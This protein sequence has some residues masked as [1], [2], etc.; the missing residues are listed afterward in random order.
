[1]LAGNP[2]SVGLM[3]GGG[4]AWISRSAGTPVVELLLSEVKLHPKYF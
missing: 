3:D 1:M 2:Y 4:Q